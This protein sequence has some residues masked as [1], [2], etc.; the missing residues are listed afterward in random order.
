M[1]GKL[2]KFVRYALGIVIAFTGGN[3]LAQFAAVPGDKGGQDMFGPYD[4]VS[5]WPQ[6][7]AELPGHDGWTYNGR[8]SW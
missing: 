8:A 3:S 7:L 2:K 1:D 6:D 4:V 5:N